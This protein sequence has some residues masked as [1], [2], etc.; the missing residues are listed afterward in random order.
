MTDRRPRRGHYLGTEFDERW[1][2]R[3]ARDGFLARGLGDW[4]LDDEALHFH[5]RLTRTPLAIAFADV[6]GVSRGSW[7]AGQWAGRDAVVKVAW[8]KDGAR[9]SSGF[10]LARDP[11][12]TEALMREIRSRARRARGPQFEDEAG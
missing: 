3:Y 1:W 9:L 2:S 10:V 8:R 12:E 4:W 7:H 5:R 6:V 11:G